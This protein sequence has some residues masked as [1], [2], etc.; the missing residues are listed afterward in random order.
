MTFIADIP[1]SI[2]QGL[3]N[4]SHEAYIPI[5]YIPSPT[6]LLLILLFY[7]TFE[8]NLLQYG[9]YYIYITFVARNLKVSH[10]CHVEIIHVQVMIHI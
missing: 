7:L 3:P 2:M 6:D 4:K 1:L 10:R 8:N 5:E 9:T